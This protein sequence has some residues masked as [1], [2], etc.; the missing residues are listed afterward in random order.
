MHASIYDKHVSFFDHDCFIDIISQMGS[1]M[2]TTC[3]FPTV[4][5][6]MIFDVVFF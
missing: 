4:P 2:C 3:V 5:K 1:V 6:Q